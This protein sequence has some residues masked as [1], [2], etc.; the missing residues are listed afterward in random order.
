MELGTPSVFADGGGE[1]VDVVVGVAYGDPA[2]A[3]VVT[4]GGNARGLDNALGYLAP[5]CV[6]EVAVLGGGA[7]GAVNSS[8]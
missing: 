3:Q 5:L 4:D 2:A 1:D 7:N 8:R 6:G